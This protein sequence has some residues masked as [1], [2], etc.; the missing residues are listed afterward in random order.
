MSSRETQQQGSKSNLPQD[1][2]DQVE[3]AKPETWQNKEEEDEYQKFE[4]ELTEDLNN[5]KRSHAQE[6]D[7]FDQRE[8]K[9]QEHEQYEM[10]ERIQHLKELLRQ[11]KRFK[12]DT[13]TNEKVATD[14][15]VN[16]KKEEG[17]ENG[18]S[19]IGYDVDWVLNWKQK[20]RVER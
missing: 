9:L 14:T 4:E 12:C 15:V 1:F 17:A 18:V 16:E 7:F 3:A 11:R 5:L 2:F 20:K 6:E 13:K 10:K 8:T 19:E